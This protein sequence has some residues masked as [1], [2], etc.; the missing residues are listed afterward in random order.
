MNAVS[1]I[2]AQ[3]ERIVDWVHDNRWCGIGGNFRVSVLAVEFV[4]NRVAEQASR[5]AKI[6]VFVS[7][8]WRAML[9]FCWMVIPMYWF[10]DT[11]T[12]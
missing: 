2:F 11:D 6:S 7:L 8:A 1:D 3:R 10:Q 4:T 12:S 5:E 9:S